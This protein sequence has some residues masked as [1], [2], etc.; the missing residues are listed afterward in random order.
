MEGECGGSDGIRNVTA[1]QHSTTQHNTNTNAN[2]KHKHNTTQHNT[3][4]EKAIQ[5]KI[6]IMEL[7]GEGWSRTFV[8]N[9]VL[10]HFL[11]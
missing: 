8:Q 4:K 1:S 9:D 6:T 10:T 5:H 2:S 3:R 11:R 7:K